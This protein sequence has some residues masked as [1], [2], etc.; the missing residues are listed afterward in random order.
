MYHSVIRSA[1]MF[2]YQ[3]N[4]V[5]PKT[6]LIRTTSRQIS[7][8]FSIIKQNHR[9]IPPYTEI[10]PIRNLSSSKRFI[11]YLKEQLNCPSNLATEICI[12][13]SEFNKR[14][15]HDVRKNVELL[16]LKGVTQKIILDNPSM[17]TINHEHLTKSLQILEEM[18]PVNTN[19]FAPLAVVP[20]EVLIKTKKDDKLSCKDRIYYF[21]KLLDVRIIPTLDVCNTKSKC[22]SDY[23]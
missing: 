22:F 20:P 19:D 3:N 14:S 2:L 23:P 11:N 17:L 5:S 21:S 18:E 13:N 16:V 7:S 10:A 9:D 12:N 8:T 15:I 6:D 1:R 4:L